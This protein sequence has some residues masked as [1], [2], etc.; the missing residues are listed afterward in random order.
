MKKNNNDTSWAILARGA[1]FQFAMVLTVLLACGFYVWRQIRITDQEMRVDLLA[2]T[3][4]MAEAVNPER[5]K[6]LSSS[7]EDLNKPEYLQ[8]K[9]Q[10]I[11]LKQ[12]NADIRFIY[13][14]GYRPD[15]TV[16]FIVD[17]EPPDS[18]D[19]SPPGQL[20]TD[21]SAVFL[22]ALKNES[23]YVEG[24]VADQW[25]V[26]VSAFVPIEDAMSGDAV[27]FLG[28]DVDAQ[29]WRKTLI[30]AGLPGVGLM[31]LLTTILLIW[32][33]LSYR[34][35]HLEA[36]APLWLTHLDILGVLA[37]GISLSLFVPWRVYLQEV[38]TRDFFFQQLATSE[39]AKISRNLKTS[40]QPN[41]RGWPH[42][43]IRGKQ[44]IRMNSC[45]FPDI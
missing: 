43:F 33:G 36:Q 31:V 2:R 14:M 34:R 18:P 10:L 6:V 1:W 44:F 25:G 23:E 45:S 15:N 9:Q 27:V 4:L 13:L 16:F 22:K 5:L 42:S 40:A 29:I 8:T 11:L 20:F 41:S 3:R 39:T 38:R 19:Y 7:K 24:P 37:F 30:Q 12:E 17:S 28:T 26:W 21:G 32:I 35:R